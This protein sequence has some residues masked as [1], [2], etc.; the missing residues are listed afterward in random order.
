MF[1]IIIII[2]IIITIG[3]FLGILGGILSF[4]PPPPQKYQ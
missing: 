4:P 1:I 2:I 3:E